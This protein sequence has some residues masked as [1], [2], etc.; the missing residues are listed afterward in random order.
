MSKS[1]LLALPP[2][3]NSLYSYSNYSYFDLMEILLVHIKKLTAISSI[4]SSKL[5]IQSTRNFYKDPSFK[6]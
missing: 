4:S 1:D 2:T 3:L 5:L 6:I